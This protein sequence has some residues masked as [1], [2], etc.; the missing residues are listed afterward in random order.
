MEVLIGL[1]IFLG[2]GFIFMVPLRGI[3][4]DKPSVIDAPV[5]KKK[6]I[7]RKDRYALARI[8]K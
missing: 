2:L 3:I 6:R 1:M 7:K 5:L 8:K 4:M